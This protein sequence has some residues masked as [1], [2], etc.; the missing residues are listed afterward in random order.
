MYF[1]HHHSTVTLQSYG[2]NNLNDS[3]II[4]KNDKQ[5]LFN[6]NDTDINAIKDKSDVQ[7]SGE[8]ADLKEEI[9][10]VLDQISQAG[11]D[12]DNM[13]GRKS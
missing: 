7:D 2:G 12:K 8:P 4:D 5:D 10:V 1:P 6:S 3:K 13:D 9:L 11:S